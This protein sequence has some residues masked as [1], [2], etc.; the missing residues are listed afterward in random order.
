MPIG[1]TPCTERFLRLREQA[2]AQ[3]ARRIDAGQP[4]W[5]FG[6]GHF[7]RALARAMQAQGLAVA[8][9][10]ETTPQAPEV[11]G[12]PV[13]DWPT[14]ARTA[15][16]AQL[17]LGILNHRTPYDQLITLACGKILGPGH[18]LQVTDIALEIGL[19]RSH[20]EQPVALLEA[21]VVHLAHLELV[22]GRVEC[23]R[24][25]GVQRQNAHQ[26]SS[27]RRR[28]RRSSSGASC[29]P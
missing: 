14:L 20:A 4:V 8:G 15:P 3:P 24:L 11:Q 19:D 25:P 6:A 26:S 17:A 28:A 9:F 16:H 5:V 13:L 1:Q 29:T 23:L 10:V 18:V 27:A 22:L 2:A 21:Q 12:L 7:G